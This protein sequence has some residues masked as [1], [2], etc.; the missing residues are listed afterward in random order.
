MLKK[1]FIIKVQEKTGATKKDVCAFLDAYEQTV[2]EALAGG[3]DVKFTGFGTYKT[4]KLA[5]REGTNPQTKKKIKIPESIVPAFKAGKA[6][7][8]AVKS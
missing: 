2:Y 4:R 7:K 1:D 8:E 5:A 3:D 6:F